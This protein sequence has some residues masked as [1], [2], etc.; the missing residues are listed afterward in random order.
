MNHIELFAGCGGLSLGL[1]TAGFELVMANELSPM[2]SATFARNILNADL[3]EQSN[4]DK[5][6]WLSSSHQRKDIQNRLS[7]NPMTAV[8]LK[9]EHHSD[10]EGKE[11]ADEELDRSL[12]IGSITDLNKI[13]ENDKNGL[14]K[15]L[16]SGLGRGGVDLV[17]GG[18]PCQ[19]FSMAGLRDHRNQRNALPWEF[20][21]FVGIVK[22]KIALLENVSGILR[23][24]DIDGEKHFAWHEVAKAFAKV[25]YIPLCLHIN[26]KYVGAAQ[27]RPRF[28]L[29]A[30]R[31]DI[32]AAFKKGTTDQGLLAAF[33]PSKL[34]VD[35]IESGHDP[36]LGE[37]KCF[38]I[39][40]DHGLFSSGILS[41]LRTHTK[42][43]L[44]S[45]KAA[46]DDL[47][48]T[49]LNQ[50][51]YVKNINSQFC[52]LHSFT[53]NNVAN[54]EFRANGPKVRARFR[55]NQVLNNLDASNASKLRNY[56][57]Y[58]GGAELDKQS[59]KEVAKH[60]LLAL[61]GKVIKKG[62]LNQIAVLLQELRTRKHSQRALQANRPAPAVL[63]S[64]D[65]TSH[66]Y[67]SESTQRTLTVRELARIQSF[68]DWYEFKSKVTTGGQRRK[69]EVPQY[70]QV[71]NAVPPLLGAALGVVCKTLLS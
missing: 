27:N 61:D 68:P 62:S 3:V 31:K 60:W 18:P 23:A 45:V 47:R 70:T 46:I 39:E 48:S 63:G 19:S 14:L 20:A 7:E 65:D 4:T 5:V 37:I 16:K 42:D 6:L 13:L 41:A 58:A 17:S 51:T 67:E 52:N 36:A 66:Y 50:S 35:R 1:E 64:P 56:I 24:F 15:Q 26:A 29:I 32:Y 21:K 53:L 11:F 28:I 69:F 8:G 9:N 10:I 40:K 44:V 2:A 34:F 33:E 59:I 38:D 25:G 55:L 12:L 57:K 71:G 30:L 43:Q 22:P 54:H 49:E